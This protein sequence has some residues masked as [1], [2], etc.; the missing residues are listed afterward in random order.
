M[1]TY[2]GATRINRIL[3]AGSVDRHLK[4][5][6][7][8][9][10]LYSQHMGAAMQNVVQIAG[11]QASR[12][13]PRLTGELASSIF[14]KYLGVNKN[15]MQV[16]GAI[17][18]DKSQGMKGLVMEVGRN[19]GA[20]RWKGFFYLYYGVVDKEKEIREEYDGANKKIVESLVTK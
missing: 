5:L 13:A 11:A 9:D 6:Q 19:Y 15:N 2:R 1:A 20:R 10:T 18:T 8:F 7:Q 4:K 14:K 12:N 17:G 16:R 3:D